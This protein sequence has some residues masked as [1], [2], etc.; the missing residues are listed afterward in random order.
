MAN[1]Q[2][3]R[4][5]LSQLCSDCWY[6]T[7]ASIAWNPESKKLQ[8]YCRYNWETAREKN[9][10]EHRTIETNPQAAMVVT[11]LS[12]GGFWKS[13]RRRK[14]LDPVLQHGVSYITWCGIYLL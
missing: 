10:L 3:S 6:W 12:S 7:K 13:S 9:R 2:Y 8:E 14:R 1:T 4:M 5:L 11:I